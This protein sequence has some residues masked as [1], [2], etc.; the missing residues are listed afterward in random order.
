MRRYPPVQ[1]TRRPLTLGIIAASAAGV[2]VMGVLVVRDAWPSSGGA[3]GA[4]S[5][6]R[7]GEA[8][9]G[10]EGGGAGGGG[11]GGGGLAALASDGFIPPGAEALRGEPGGL[12]PLPGGESMIRFARSGAGTGR[13]EVS[14]WRVDA[15]RLAEARAW[16]RREARRRGWRVER[17]QESAKGGPGGGW[18]LVLVPMERRAGEAMRVLSIRGERQGEEGGEGGEGGE[19]RVTLV[20]RYDGSGDGKASQ[21]AAGGA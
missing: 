12:D 8:W 13:E 19:G 6:P 21:T 10:G 15:A 20:M 9:S 18:S 3:S 2:A 5:T 14:L 17:R 11:G 7:P 16:Y 1:P 4:A